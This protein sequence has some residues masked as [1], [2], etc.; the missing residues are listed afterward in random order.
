MCET[1]FLHA[2][3]LVEFELCMLKWWLWSKCNQNNFVV[4]LLQSK[5]YTVPSS[6][7][8]PD[9]TVGRSQFANLTSCPQQCAEVPSA[10]YPPI[11]IL[12][13]YCTWSPLH[14]TVAQTMISEIAS[15]SVMGTN[16]TAHKLASHHYLISA[17]DI[18]SCA[19]THR[20]LHIN[21]CRGH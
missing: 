17:M 12:Y 4:A 3:M 19:W 10:Q 14:Y 8:T 1:I 9:Y 11:W 16:F 6:A 15:N 20:V 7:F 2:T 13:I 5:S 21:Y 18:I